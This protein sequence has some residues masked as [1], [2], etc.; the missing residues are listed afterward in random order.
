[1]RLNVVQTLVSKV[2]KFVSNV[3]LTIIKGFKMSTRTDKEK[4]VLKEVKFF[5]DFLYSVL[6]LTA[7]RIL[8][9]PFYSKRAKNFD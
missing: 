9:E 2:F 1:M 4:T 5:A 6:R 3:S 8:V 7:F